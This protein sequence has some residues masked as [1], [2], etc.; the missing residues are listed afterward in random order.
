MNCKQLI[1]SQE[2]R[3]EPSVQL[4]QHCSRRN[5][6]EADQTSASRSF[7]STRS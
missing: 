6:N 7:I 1:Q 2:T 5:K 3:I 4:W